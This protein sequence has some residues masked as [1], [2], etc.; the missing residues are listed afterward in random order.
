MNQTNKRL[1]IE[2]LYLTKRGDIRTSIWGEFLTND[3]KWEKIADREKGER[4]EE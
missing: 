3:F 4:R 1:E 2:N